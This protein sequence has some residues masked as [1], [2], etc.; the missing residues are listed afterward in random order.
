MSLPRICLVVDALLQKH[1]VEVEA[2]G[3]SKPTG[4]AFSV[5][6]IRSNPAAVGA[7]TGDATYGF[8]LNSLLDAGGRGDGVH[9]C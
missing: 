6:S 9:F 4:E 7:V 5:R 2:V 3:P 8:F 1:I